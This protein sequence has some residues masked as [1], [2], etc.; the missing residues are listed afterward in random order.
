LFIERSSTEETIPMKRIYFLVPDHDSAHAIVDDLVAN[1]IDQTHISVIA[2]Q[3]KSLEDLPEATQLE[4]SDWAPALQRGIAMGGSIGLFAGT[5]ALAFEPVGLI[6]GGGALLLGSTV[7]GASFGA[8]AST[9]I[10]VST[11]NTQLEKFEDAIVRGQILML[12][13]VPKQRIEEIH[14]TIRRHHPEADFEGVEPTVK[15]MPQKE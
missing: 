12:V 13:D 10:G 3:E 9:L 5:A 15:V 8:W 4:K 11:P 2:K 6:V 14:N 1:G 7:G